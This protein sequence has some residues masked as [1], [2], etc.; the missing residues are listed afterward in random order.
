MHCKCQSPRWR[1]LLK[2]GGVVVSDRGPR[3]GL[4]LLK[5]AFG[6]KSQNKSLPGLVTGHGVGVHSFFVPLLHQSSILSSGMIFPVFVSQN[7][8]KDTENK[9]VSLVRRIT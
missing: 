4:A 1:K 8:D 9:T 2:I 6:A 3:H 5:A 7:C